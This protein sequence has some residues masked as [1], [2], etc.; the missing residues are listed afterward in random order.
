MPDPRHPPP[1]G[2]FVVYSNGRGYWSGEHWVR[3]VDQ[4]MQFRTPRR[5]WLDANAVVQSMRAAGTPCVI[6]YLPRRQPRPRKGAA[7]DA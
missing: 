5:A 3:S 6:Q 2:C 1:E 4:A 7:P